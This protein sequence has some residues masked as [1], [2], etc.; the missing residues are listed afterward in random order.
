M[1]IIAISVAV[2]GTVVRL[3]LFFPRVSNSISKQ[4]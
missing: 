4:A 3:A 2:V 1:T